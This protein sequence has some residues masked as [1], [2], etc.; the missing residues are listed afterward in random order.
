[1]SDL[2]K[3]ARFIIHGR[4]QG[5]FFRDSTRQVAKT[6]DIKG[7]AVNQSDGTV[8]VIADG[9]Q[10][11]LRKLKSWLMVGPDMAEVE[12][13]EEVDIECHQEFNDFTIG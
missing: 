10:D 5:V 7:L 9:T 8:A 12:K 13:V 3:I 1:M 2:K 11:S 6:L 4:V